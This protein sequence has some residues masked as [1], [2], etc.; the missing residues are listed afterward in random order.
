MANVD[1]SNA[2]IE[3]ILNNPIKRPNVALA[4]Y[5]LNDSSGNQIGTVTATR[6]VNQSK[7]MLYSYSAT[8]SASGTEFYFSDSN[9][10]MFYRV[11]NIS[12]ANGDTGVFQVDAGLVV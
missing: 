5:R 9:S 6:L 8:F 11:Y 1:F 4:A 2:H 7:R 12:F 10:T 3:P